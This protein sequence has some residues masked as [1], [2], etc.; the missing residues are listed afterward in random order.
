MILNSFASLPHSITKCG[1]QKS[2]GAPKVTSFSLCPLSDFGIHYQIFFN[3]SHDQIYLYSLAGHAGLLAKLTHF[4][5]LS[6][7]PLQPYLS[8]LLS[9]RSLV[10]LHM[11]LCLMWHSFSCLMNS[12]T[13]FC[14]KPNISS[15]KPSLTTTLFSW[16]LFNFS[17]QTHIELPI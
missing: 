13:A 17:I 11:V 9:S 8:V 16:P 4:A 10:F 7:M 3:S 2:L 12:Y 1:H 5:A 14:G 6:L 15:G